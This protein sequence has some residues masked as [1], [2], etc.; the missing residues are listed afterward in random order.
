MS[1]LARVETETEIKRWTECYASA[2]KKTG[3]ISTLQLPQR[4]QRSW[5]MKDIEKMIQYAEMNTTSNIYL[6]LNAFSFGSRKESDL[7]QIRNIGLDLDI[8]NVGAT[9]EEAGDEIQALILDQVIPEPNLLI[10]SGR[11]LQ[12][13]YGIKGGAAPTISWLSRYI[14]SQYISKLSFLGADSQTTDPTRVLRFPNT[15]NQKNMAK[16]TVDI[17]NPVEYDLGTLY[18]YCTPIED[19][20]KSRRKKKKKEVVVLPS[21]RGIVNLYSL[22]TKKKDDLDRLLDLR[23]GV[24]TGYRNT[25]LYTYCFTIALILKEQKSTIVFARQ[26][27]ERFKEPLL[28]KELES[29]A[30][31]ACKDALDFLKA[32]KANEYKMIGLPSNLIKP[33]K[34]STIIRKLDITDEEIEHMRVLINRET[35]RKRNTEYVRDKRGS[36]TQEEHIK[37]KRQKVDEKIGQ[38]RELLESSPDMTNRMLAEE[39]QVTVRRVQQLKKEIKNNSSHE[40]TVT[41]ERS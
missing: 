4:I 20:R 2:N 11:G 38:L 1:I 33:E 14:T 10:D 39:L 24:M 40:I 16:T 21:P 31:S 12:L 23:N 3:F 41:I 30:K 17:W 19:T 28:I 27:N 26:A 7:R 13:I 8:Y 32:F 5:G 9:V 36:I 37:N 18:S 25:Y 15:V 6:S 34:A 35:K 22:N 29:V